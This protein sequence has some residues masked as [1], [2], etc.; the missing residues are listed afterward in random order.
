MYQNKNLSR[1]IEP[2]KYLNL[3]DARI[4]P[5]SQREELRI[6][7]QV[8]EVQGMKSVLDRLDPFIVAL[9]FIIFQFFLSSVRSK[10][11]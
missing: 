8:L 2:S 5:E 1:S 11:D 7:L 4:S 9:H 6:A 10:I 3:H